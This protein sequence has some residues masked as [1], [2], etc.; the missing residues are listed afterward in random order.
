MLARAAVRTVS[1][2]LGV[3][4]CRCGSS[5]TIIIVSAFKRARFAVSLPHSHVA[6]DSYSA[7]LVS[8]RLAELGAL[9]EAG[10][11]LGAEDVERLRLDFHPPVD[12]RRGIR[13]DGIHVEILLLLCR[14]EQAKSQTKVALMAD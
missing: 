7:T 2:V 3:V 11:L 9:H 10:K 6:S 4:G 5:A 13:V 8:D 1:I 12:A 14:L